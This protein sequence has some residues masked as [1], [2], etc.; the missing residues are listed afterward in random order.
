[1]KTLQQVQC[2]C[3]QCTGQGCNQQAA[4]MGGAPGVCSWLLKKGAIRLQILEAG[5]SVPGAKV[6]GASKGRAD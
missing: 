3:V 5:A 6:A 4:D 1:M 2:M